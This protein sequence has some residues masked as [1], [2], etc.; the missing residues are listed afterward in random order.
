[1]KKTKKLGGPPMKYSAMVFAFGEP[2]L[3]IMGDD[4]PR[5][6]RLSALKI[7]VTAWNAIVADEALGTSEHV[8]ELRRSVGALPAPGGLL[9]R[10]AVEELI[11]RKRM[12]F[13]EERWLI[14]KWQ[15]LGEGDDLR[16]RV[17]AHAPPAPR[18]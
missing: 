14:G 12:L 1:M 7:I 13:R 4:A 9:F 8:A 17:E 2:L 10:S 3:L 15:L 6:V 5:E 11:E 16:L 18:R